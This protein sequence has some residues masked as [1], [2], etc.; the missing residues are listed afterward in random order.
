MIYL[1]SFLQKFGFTQ[2]SDKEINTGNNFSNYENFKNFID[3]HYGLDHLQKYNYI[4]YVKVMRQ[5]I[6]I[7]DEEIYDKHINNIRILIKV[8][9]ELRI[10]KNIDILKYMFKL[11]S[12]FKLIE[13]KKYIAFNTIKTIRE[14]SYSK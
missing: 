7:R 12:F 13:E 3:D 5:I 2:I 4:K 8:M 14:S 10:F 1:K 11:D 6:K 9:F